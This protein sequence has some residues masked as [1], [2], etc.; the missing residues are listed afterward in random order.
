M[1]STDE[2]QPEYGHP[3]NAAGY[4][5]TD[6][7]AVWEENSGGD[8]DDEVQR[9]RQNVPDVFVDRRGGTE[10]MSPH[11]GNTTFFH[12]ASIYQVTF[13]KKIIQ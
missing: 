2:I 9:E 10:S 7:N 13:K 11:T 6:Y 3:N 8:D 12:Q 4:P 1:D 5:G